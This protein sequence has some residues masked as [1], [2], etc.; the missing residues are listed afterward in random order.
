M[1][2]DISLQLSAA[3]TRNAGATP[4]VGAAPARASGAALITALLLVVL[5][6]GIV[7]QLLAAQSHALSRVVRAQAQTQLTLFAT[8]SLD[9]ARSALLEDSKLSSIDHLG[10][11][12]ARGLPPQPVG[13]GASAGVATGIIKDETA[14]FNVNNLVSDQGVK[15]QADVEIFQ[16]LLAALGLDT[17]LSHAVLDWLDIDDEAT[18][19]GGAETSTYMAKTPPYRPANRRMVQVEELLRV[20]GINQ[21][22]FNRLQ[23]FVTALPTRTKIN[24]NTA[25]QQ[26][27]SA[28]LP[29]LV[30][31]DAKAFITLRTDKPFAN[32]GAVRAAL[33][34]LEPSSLDQQCDVRT[35][36]FEVFIAVENAEGR[37]RLNALMQRPFSSALNPSGPVVTASW[38][39]IIW[40]RNF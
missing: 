9:W 30:G 12:W 13:S 7:S 26:L 31:D 10:E 19:P 24:L 36:Y 34:G 8:P 27:L 6:A 3:S 16:R 38:P 18:F 33:K 37:V 40:V 1:Q 29:R 5:V 39:S 17:A 22:I 14:K 20:H 11:M 4:N 25:P 2:A 15:S 32:I 28:V 21:T 23:P 35:D